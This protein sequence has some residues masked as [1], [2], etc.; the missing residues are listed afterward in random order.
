MLKQLYHL[1]R[2][3][4][5]MITSTTRTTP[6][7]SLELI[8]NLPPLEIYLEE[9]G[10]ITYARLYPQLGKPW[11]SKTT[12]RIP[13]LTSWHSLLKA[14][15]TDTTDDR[16]SHT[17]WDK[18]YHIMTSSF[19]TN[20]TSIKPSEFTIYTD[21]SKTDNG[22][23]AGFVIYHKCDRIHTESISLPDTTTVFH[24]EVTAIY[25]AMLQ[26]IR[27]DRTQTLSY[28]KILSDSQ[29]A[30]K[31]LDSHDIKSKIVLQT[32]EALNAVADIT[33]STSCLLYTSPSP[34]D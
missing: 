6:Q 28:V 26:L 8:Y 32:I 3:A 21:G 24:A 16:C 13:H 4:C 11:T 25:K 30:I 31:A 19:I 23:G 18:C 1:N 20:R 29:A 10:L 7:A 17:N 12:F 14:T 34:R 22:T 15:N 5:M 33:I 2:T 27:M 9:I